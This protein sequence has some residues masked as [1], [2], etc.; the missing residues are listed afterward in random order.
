M[1]GPAARERARVGLAAGGGARAGLAVVSAA[2]VVVGW[3]LG[4]RGVDLPAQLYRVELF[5]HHGLLLWDSQ[6]YGGHWTLDY[7]VVYPPLAGVLGMETV[8]AF[9]AAV[10][11]A[12]FDRL[13]VGSFGP[14]ARLSSAVFA[15][16]V[17]VETSIGQLAFFTGEAFGLG[18]LWCLVGARRRWVPATALALLATLSSPLAGAFTALAVASWGLTL[19]RRARRVDR[20]V[21]WCVAVV[22]A[23]L[24]PVAVSS[25]L[26]PGQGPMPYPVVDWLWEAV[27][28]VVLWGVA[29]RHR[30]VLRTGMVLY[31]VVTVFAVAV[32]SPLGGNIGRLEDVAA[33]PL[34]VATAAAGGSWVRMPVLLRRGAFAGA[35][36]V[37]GLSQWDPAWAALTTNAGQAW[38]AESYYA[39]LV[40]YLQRVDEQGG[41]PVGRVEVVPTEDHW[42]A[43]YV[44]PELPLARGWERQ[45]D[46]ADN[47]L[48]YGKAPLTSATYLAWLRRDGVR[49]VALAAA[50]TDSAGTA[51]ARLVR[52]GVGGTTLAWHTADWQV[53]RVAGP[54]LV[55]GPVRLQVISGDHVELTATGAGDSVIRIRWGGHWRVVEGRARL[56]RAAGGWVL[57]DARG[58]GQIGLEV[59]LAP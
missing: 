3:A 46:V 59:S 23:G 28:A 25:A 2:L 1:T 6:W 18:C 55:S 29:G 57:L 14:R 22:A 53:Y 39:P 45:L 38:T 40:A 5:R 30:E 48:F 56:S 58:P 13:V 10:A 41:A 4:W 49:Y 37:F 52:R 50:P 19:L 12:A 33:L 31:L 34:L 42:E 35:A 9:S 44:A 27:V 21:W 15:L 36:V 8:A 20:S 47:P 26:F 54:G 32:P 16:S 7:S 24:V 17:V 11:T 51:E 43:A